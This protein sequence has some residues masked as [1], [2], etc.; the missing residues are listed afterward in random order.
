MLMP[1]E[2]GCKNLTLAGKPTHLQYLSKTIGTTLSSYTKAI[3]IQNQTTGNLFQKKTK[4]KNLSTDCGLVDNCTNTNYLL[5]CFDY[6]HNNP[7]KGKLV[8]NLKDW[9]YSSYPDYYGFRNGT[10][11][12]K[13][14]AMQ[15]L[16]LIEDY[17]T[18]YNLAEI[19]EAVIKKIFQP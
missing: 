2:Q 14:L 8:K 5:T 9:S 19:D 4:A 15:I 3:N 11:C 12:N 6:I 13:S 1:N 16:G 10:L 18:N 7:L 17:F